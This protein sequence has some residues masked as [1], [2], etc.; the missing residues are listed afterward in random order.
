M[1]SKHARRLR[2]KAIAVRRAQRATVQRPVCRRCGSLKTRR[3]QFGPFNGWMV[4]EPCQ[5][6]HL[7]SFRQREAT[8]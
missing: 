5:A 4:C 3:S 6:R 1:S 7:A 2:R 8:P